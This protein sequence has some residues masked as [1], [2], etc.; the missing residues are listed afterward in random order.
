MFLSL[1]AATKIEGDSIKEP[2]AESIAELL[3]SFVSASHDLTG[4]VDQESFVAKYLLPD[5]AAIGEADI[6]EPFAWFV[7]STAGV[8]GADEWL[9]ANPEQVDALVQ[10]FQFQ[11]A[12]RDEASE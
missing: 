6:D 7:A 9:D 1:N 12:R 4:D 8:E 5:V 10:H 2:V 11:A 3:A